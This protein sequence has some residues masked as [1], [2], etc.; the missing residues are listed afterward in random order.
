[1]QVPKW[2]RT[3][4]PRHPLTVGGGPVLSRR[5]A[6]GALFPETARAGLDVAWTHAPTAPGQHCEFGASATGMHR[7]RDRPIRSFQSYEHF[8]LGR[9]WAGR[10][11]S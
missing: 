9:R 5:R 2:L 8:A 1:M 7:S 11:C 4:L 3:T 10:L 6:T